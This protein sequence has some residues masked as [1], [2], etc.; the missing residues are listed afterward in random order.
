[1][2]ASDDGDEVVAI[3]SS[4]VAARHEGPQKSR[5]SFILLGL[6]AVATIIFPII[7]VPSDKPITSS[8]KFMRN[9]T[10]VR[11]QYFT[12]DVSLD[13]L[14]RRGGGNF[15]N[16]VSGCSIARWVHTYPNISGKKAHMNDCATND[17][18]AHHR[19]EDDTVIQAFDTIYVPY[20]KLTSFLKSNF[21]SINQ[22]Y[23]L[24]TGQNMDTKPI[25]EE[26][27]NQIINNKYVAKWFVTQLGKF[28]QNRSSD[29]PKVTS[30]PYGLDRKFFQNYTNEL[31]RANVTKTSLLFL[32]YLEVYNNPV[33]RKDVPSGPRKT[34]AEYL[35]AL[36]EAQYILA[37][38]GDRPECFRHFEALMLG[39][40]PLTQLL[41][42]EYPHLIGSGVIFDNHE[43]NLTVLERDLPKRSNGT[44]NRRFVFE[45]F[46][47][48]YVDRV[49][50]RPLMWWDRL[51]DSPATS[52]DLADRFRERLMAKETVS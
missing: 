30:F 52:Q 15:I 19:L 33:Q 13:D 12:N 43:W 6:L 2:D 20:R 47:M 35:S 14:I 8:I 26:E 34:I 41:E 3:R 18:S 46:W 40:V 21:L 37:P 1:M 4:I 9:A 32:S 39:T 28:G 44:V 7:L 38:D 22:S 48:E 50:G 31:N 42:R 51:T 10:V 27:F 23:V 36:H 24:I 17:V 29:H 11:G 45:E 16:P 49:V 5:L 25:P